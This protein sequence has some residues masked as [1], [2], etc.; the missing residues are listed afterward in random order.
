MF[1][2]ITCT[3][4]LHY[5]HPINGWTYQDGL[6]AVPAKTSKGARAS[7]MTEILSDAVQ[8][9]LPAAKS[10]AIKDAA[11]HIGKIFGRDINR[12]QALGFT[13]SYTPD[14]SQLTLDKIQRAKTTDELQ[15]ILV[16]LPVKGKQ[17][18]A[19]VIKNR[20]EVLNVKADTSGATKRAL[21][22]STTR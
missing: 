1:N 5:K 8:T 9:G 19:Q 14:E 13:A 4:R 17:A 22:P 21:V 6:G 16:N 7:D 18:Y 10:Y 2:S 12:K 20:M 15:E 11:E 3:V